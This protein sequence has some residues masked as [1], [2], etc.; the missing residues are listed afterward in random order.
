M[1]TIISKHRLSEL[2]IRSS[3]NYLLDKAAHDEQLRQLAV[4]ITSNKEPI[5][6]VYDWV[7]ENVQYVPDPVGNELFISPVR[8]VQDYHDGN[9]LAGD[10][11]DQ[12]LLITALCRSI[13][14]ESNVVLLDTGGGGL[15]H[16]VSQA[17]SE[18][19]G[20]YVLVDASTN[21][22]PLGWEESYFQKVVV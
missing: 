9:P 6:A 12:A 14:I 10:C 21:E 5:S 13:G 16:A 7:K 1:L 17:Y 2:D 18:K 8:M 11:D 3:I 20:K 4:Q 19:L 15:D 22:V